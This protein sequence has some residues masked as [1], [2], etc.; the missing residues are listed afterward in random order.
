MYVYLHTK[1]VASIL[2]FCL[3][4]YII[5]SNFNFADFY[6][7]ALF[8]P[9]FDNAEVCNYCVNSSLLYKVFRE[10]QQKNFITISGVWPLRGWWDL[11]ESVK[12]RKCVT[13][14]VNVE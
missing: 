11:S 12:R 4:V 3:P 7:H 8:R 6:H 10:H 9:I 5:H 13:N 14:N 2:L 1:T